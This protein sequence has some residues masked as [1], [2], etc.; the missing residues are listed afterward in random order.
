MAFDGFIKIRYGTWYREIDGTPWTSLI[1]KKRKTIESNS[2]KQITGKQNGYFVVTKN[3]SWHR[4]V[5]EYF[6][7]PIPED[8]QVDH[9]DNNKLNNLIDNLQLLNNSKNNSKKPISTRN[10]SGYPGVCYN[11]KSNKYYS[12]IR[13]NGEVYWLGSYYSPLEAFEEYLIAKVYYHGFE[14]IL[15]LS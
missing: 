5:W 14:S 7:G 15:P 2:L 10:T 1:R 13:T 3:I 4:L 8:M 12:Q 6:K 9:R 11:S